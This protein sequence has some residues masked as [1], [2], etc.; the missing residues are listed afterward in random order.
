VGHIAANLMPGMEEDGDQRPHCRLADGSRVDLAG[1]RKSTF[2]T[3]IAG[4]FRATSRDCMLLT[5]CA[6]FTLPYKR[7]ARTFPPF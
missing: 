2:G 1:L 7:C 3:A 5:V 6:P 4:W